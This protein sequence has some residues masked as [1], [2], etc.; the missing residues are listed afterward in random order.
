MWLRQFWFTFL[1]LGCGSTDNEDVAQSQHG[2]DAPEEPQMA[3]PPEGLN[4]CEVGERRA[5]LAGEDGSHCVCSEFKVWHCFGVSEERQIGGN[6]TCKTSLA[7]GQTSPC[8]RTYSDC[9]DSRTYSTKC[10]GEGDDS[11]CICVVN[12]TPVGQLEPGIPCVADVTTANDLCSWSLE[13][14]NQ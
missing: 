12:A 10:Y 3:L 7:F 13:L 11:V 8:E 14:V 4:E 6:A 1:M 2:D 9:S 5:A